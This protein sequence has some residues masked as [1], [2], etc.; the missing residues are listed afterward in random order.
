[1]W[2]G[3][4]E[5]WEKELAD[6]DKQIEVAIAARALLKSEYKNYRKR[7]DSVRAEAFRLGM[8][9]QT[10]ILHRLRP[11]RRKHLADRPGASA[12]ALRREF[13]EFDKACQFL[14]LTPPFNTD[15]YKAAYRAA[16]RRHHP[17]H[18]GTTEQFLALTKACE[19]ILSHGPRLRRD[20][21]K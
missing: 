5:K 6:Y 16:A 21:G 19:V 10:E 9:A 18:G 3:T 8:I 12:D 15:D 7:G 20:L 13:D 14:G 1:M 11:W 4:Y 17:D 2:F